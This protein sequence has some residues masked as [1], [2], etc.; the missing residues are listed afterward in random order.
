MTKNL[1]ISITRFKLAALAW[2]SEGG[3]PLLAIHG[4]LDNAASFKPL[5]PYLPGFHTVALDLPGHGHSQ[6]RGDG[7]YYHFL[8]YLS[9]IR[10][11]VVQLGWDQFNLLGHSLGSGI[12]SLY[13][14]LYPESVAKLALIDG[15]G[16][17]A[18]SSVDAVKTHRMAMQ[19]MARVSE[20]PHSVYSNIDK[21]INARLNVGKLSGKS[22]RL[23][24]ERNSLKTA[25]GISWR[26]DRKLKVRTPLYL[27]EDQVLAYLEEIVCPVL[28]VRPDN[29]NLHDRTYMP[30]RY[31]QVKNL[32]IKNV[33][34]AHHVHMDHPK[35]VAGVLNNFFS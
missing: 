28:L 5:A 4:W 29:G 13:S 35:V 20:R 22:A 26:T 10:E 27:T 9:V 7:E 25:H 30:A 15:L 2:G 3:S 8:D 18:A 12:A 11:V 14:A 21:A 23:L 6:H 16:P 17:F 33:S 34:G 1:E 31:A 19:Q 24:V 32:T